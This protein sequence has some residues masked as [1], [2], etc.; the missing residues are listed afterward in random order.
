MRQLKQL[1]I[2]ISKIEF[3]IK[4]LPQKETGG[5]DGFIGESYQTFQG[6]TISAENKLSRKLKFILIH[7][8]RPAFS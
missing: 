4:N 5:P 2:S 7:S 1:F 6:E 8:T 3:L